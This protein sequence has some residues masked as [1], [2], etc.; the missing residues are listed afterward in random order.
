MAVES[1]YFPKLGREV[2]ALGLG[3]GGRRTERSEEKT[4]LEA[5]VRA[6]ELGIR[7]ID[8]AEIYSGGF[9]EEVVGKALRA[10]SGDRED[11]FIVTKIHPRNLVDE[12][13]IRRSLAGSL[14][15]M[16]LEYVDSYLIH[17]LERDTD[18]KLAVKTLE[19]L[20]REGLVGSIGVSNFTVEKIEEARSYLSHTD[21]AVVENRY[22]LTHRGDEETVIP[23]CRREGMMYLAYTPLDKGALLENRK[24]A[25]VA[26]K[27]GKTPIQVL[28]NW[29][30]NIEPVVPIPRASR[31]EH[32]EELAGALG[33]RLS[34]ED[35]EYIGERVG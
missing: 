20:W 35:Q 33:W 26:R 21:I 6:L 5:I 29:Y 19:E 24:L 15:R 13:S 1:K 22:S 2:P 14:E 25:E 30:I 27:Y 17:W 9:A 18:L 4:W 23:Y 3:T 34:R 32:V 12:H 7:L 11:V 10:W 16:G 8:T 31:R 28:L